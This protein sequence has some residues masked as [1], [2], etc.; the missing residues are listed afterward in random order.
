MNTHV[1][2][3]DVRHNVP[4]ADTIAPD[5]RHDVPNTQ[6]ISPDIR[7]NTLE[8]RGDTNRQNSAVG[9]THTLPVAES[10]PTTPRTHARSAILIE[11]E[12]SI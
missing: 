1:T 5:V 9:I 4:N 6:P 7:R 8:S 10:P 11:K 3:S 2:I 12:S